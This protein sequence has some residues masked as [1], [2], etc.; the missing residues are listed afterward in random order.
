MPKLAKV[1]GRAFATGDRVPVVALY[2]GRQP[3]PKWDNFYPS[4]A[5]FATDDPAELARVEASIGDREWAEL[6]EALF[7]IPKPYHNGLFP[8]DLPPAEA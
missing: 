7:Q 3:T 1:K 4:P 2:S 5:V 6:N 8:V